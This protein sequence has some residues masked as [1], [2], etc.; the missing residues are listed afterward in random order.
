MV[1]STY[2][3]L[4]FGRV[5]ETSIDIIARLKSIWRFNKISNWNHTKSV[6]QNANSKKNV[7]FVKNLRFKM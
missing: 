6:F 2:F 3:S 1:A 7:K 5:P 4:N